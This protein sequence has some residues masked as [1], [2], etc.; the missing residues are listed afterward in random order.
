MAKFKRSFSSKGELELETGTIY[1]LKKK[2]KDEE[3]VEV[4]LWSFLREFDG[5]TISI[6]ISEESE[7]DSIEVE[8][9]EIEE[10]E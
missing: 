7:V 5:K 1:E 10:D 4:D 9:T 6:S 8:D 2:G 3:I